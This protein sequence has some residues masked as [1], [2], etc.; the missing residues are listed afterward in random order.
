MFGLALCGSWVVVWD[1]VI[2]DVGNRAAEARVSRIRF[3]DLIVRFIGFGVSRVYNDSEF[4]GLGLGNV[5]GRMLHH[6]IEGVLNDASFPQATVVMGIA[7]V[8]ATAF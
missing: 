1:V 3:W 4:E 2:W 8:L 5:D 7:V 6:P